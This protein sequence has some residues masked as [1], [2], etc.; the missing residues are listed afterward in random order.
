ME[1][2]C[3]TCLR[4]SK[5]LLPLFGDT[6]L[7]YKIK[8]IAS[9]EVS[10]DDKLPAKVCAECIVNINLCYNFR[11]VI[12]NSDLELKDRY[13]FLKKEQCEIEINDI[14]EESDAED[15]YKINIVKYENASSEYV[16]EEVEEADD[17]YVDTSTNNDKSKIELATLTK[18]INVSESDTNINVIKRIHSNKSSSKNKLYKCDKC[19]FE[20]TERRKYKNHEQNHLMKICNICGKFISAPNMRKHITT[21]TDQP[22]ACKECGKICKNNESL[23]G[24]VIIHKG[25][26]RKCKICGEAYTERAAY[27]AHMKTHKTIE[28]K[29]ARCPLCDKL[30]Y[31]KQGLKKHIRSHTGERP[32]PCEF[33]KKGFSSSHALKTHRRQ[34]TNERPYKCALCPMAFPQKVSLR[35]HLKSK[36]QMGNSDN[37]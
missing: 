3:R 17:L 22:V 9:V 13:A 30:L 21:H 7:P 1:N 31:G 8:T 18:N 2:V 28:E 19:N 35:T 20:S 6:K 36:H 25:I 23:R 27:V 15:S 4:S 37:S 29:T 10:E 11:R 24:H 33:C 26:N 32:Y 14:N 5:E 34:H 16:D 12:I